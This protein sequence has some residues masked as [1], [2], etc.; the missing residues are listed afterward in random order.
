MPQE[1]SPEFIGAYT[2]LLVAAWTDENER[3]QL[4]AD[5]AGYAAAKGLPVEQGSVVRVDDT[6]HDGLFTQD[7]V[8][9]AWSSTPGEHV[10]LVPA[11]PVV[12]LD[13]LDE[14]DLEAIAAGTAPVNVNVNVYAIA[15]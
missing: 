14:A 10:L 4:L 8:L 12:D 6:P 5:P 1:M 15:V 11:T 7:E 2:S 3:A 13:E 9:A